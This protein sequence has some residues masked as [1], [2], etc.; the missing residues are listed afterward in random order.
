[1]ER[2]SIL[3]HGAAFLLHDRLLNSSDIHDAHI[4]MRCGSL[5]SPIRI[6]PSQGE[7]SSDRMKCLTCDTADTVRSVPMPYVTRYLVAE[8]AA[9]NIRVS[10][11]LKAYH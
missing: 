6:K 4:C 3:A 7:T 10:F 1:M 9:M 2:D 5:L 8:M 11:D